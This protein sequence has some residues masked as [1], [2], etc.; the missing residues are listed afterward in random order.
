MVAPPVVVVMVT[1]VERGEGARH[2]AEARGAAHWMVYTPEAM[3]L[4]VKPVL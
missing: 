3:V 1:A 4:L 2:R